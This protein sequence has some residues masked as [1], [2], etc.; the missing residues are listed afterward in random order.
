MLQLMFVPKVSFLHNK[1]IQKNYNFTSFDL[2][3]TNYKN[4]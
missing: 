2:Y 3:E 1:V 4:F